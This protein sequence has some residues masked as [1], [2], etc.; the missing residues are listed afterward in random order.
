M[1]MPFF[2]KVLILSFIF[3]CNRN[4]VENNY[5]FASNPILKDDYKVEIRYSD[6]IR[7]DNKLDEE[8]IG[9]W[10]INYMIKLNDEKAILLKYRERKYLYNSDSFEDFEWGTPERSEL[11]N[12]KYAEIKF[13]LD[14]ITSFNL[15]NINSKFRSHP[16]DNVMLIT[17]NDSLYSFNLSIRDDSTTYQPIVYM[18]SKYLS[19]LEKSFVKKSE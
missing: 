11:E 2:V 7:I 5:K 4:A 12:E 1:K 8:I 3:S 10:F 13:Y 18:F 17:K 9:Y 15:K 14:S 19:Q 6:Y 16:D